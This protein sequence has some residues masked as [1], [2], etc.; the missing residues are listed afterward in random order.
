V[1]AGGK[2]MLATNRPGKRSG[3]VIRASA[4]E[5]Q[6]RNSET[7]SFWFIWNLDV[8]RDDPYDSAV[9]PH[10][11]RISC[12]LMLYEGLANGARQRPLDE[13]NVL[14]TLDQGSSVRL[15]V[16]HKSAPTSATSR[17]L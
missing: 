2:R 13:I 10:A 15:I 6:N 8:V 14:D 7:N 1:S 16:D 9:T 5:I 12:L 4:P 3:G 11:Y 17:G